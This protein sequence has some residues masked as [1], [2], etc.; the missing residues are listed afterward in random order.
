MNIFTENNILMENGG[1]DAASAVR[2]NS[3]T[4]GGTF[5]LRRAY[6]FSEAGKLLLSVEQQRAL[7]RLIREDDPETKQKTI[8]HNLRMVVTIAK[9][10]TN[11]GLDLFE[12]VR[13]GNQGLIHA[14]E[15]F[16]SAKGFRFSIF[17]TW[18]ISQSIEQALQDAA[19]EP[20]SF[21]DVAM[22]AAAF[23]NAASRGGEHD[24]RPA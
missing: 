23:L 17:S 2:M 4:S 16:E 14:L 10:Y 18:C 12:L 7:T 3:S 24:G 21:H 1:T 5:S 6:Y 19:R 22:P 15:E 13:A 8:V 11:R 9:R 20:Q